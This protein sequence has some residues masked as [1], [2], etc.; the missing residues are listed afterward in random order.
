MPQRFTLPAIHPGNIFH[1]VPRPLLELRQLAQQ[2][3]N[4][5]AW[6]ALCYLGKEVFGIQAANTFEAK[7]R[8][9]HA[10]IEWF[11]ELN[12]HIDIDGWAPRDTQAYLNHLE[13][14]GRAPSTIN[15]AFAT[16]RRLCRWAH[17]QAERPTPFRHGLPTRGIKELVVDEADAKKLSNREIHLLQ[18]AADALVLTESRRNARP[19]RNRAIFAVLYFTGMRV[20]ELCALRLEQYRGA[21]LQNVKR[22]GKNR[23]AELQL[24]DECRSAID[25]YLKHERPKD[26]TGGELAPLFVG[27]RRKQLTRQQ[28]ANILERIAEEANKHRKDSDRIQIHPHR[29]RHTAGAKIRKQT[30]SDYETAAFLGHASIKYIGMYGRPT[31]AERKETLEEAFKAET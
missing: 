2:A 19:R 17:E 30:H 8:D 23:T 1:K 14:L 16:L 22:K 18:K 15:R 20:S 24:T 13:R 28:V 21:E 25:D 3:D 31:K 10:F 26:D 29:L 9:L 12:G 4:T 5:I 11:A 27:T 7:S 6:W